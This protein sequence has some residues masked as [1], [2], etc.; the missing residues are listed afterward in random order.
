MS[1][2]EASGAARRYNRRMSADENDSRERRRRERARW[3]IARFRLG[4][5]PS[6]DL[7]ATTT[8]VERI[9]MM[10]EL[11]EM[12]WKLAGR[13]LPRYTRAQMPA[14]LY[15]PGTPARDDDDA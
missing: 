6:D 15:R 3:P 10:W 1:R 12:A 13:E 2:A 9:A 4:H 14:I 5:E 11:A 8:P 7:S